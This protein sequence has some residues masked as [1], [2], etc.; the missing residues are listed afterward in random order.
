MGMIL[1]NINEESLF[2]DLLNKLV[3]EKMKEVLMET[4]E[5]EVEKVLDLA[6][7]DFEIAVKQYVYSADREK[8]IDYTLKFKRET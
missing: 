5:R 3:R 8:F 4:A 6:A 7:K 1:D 2:T